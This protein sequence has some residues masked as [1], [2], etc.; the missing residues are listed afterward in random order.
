MNFVS[1]F[2]KHLPQDKS[3]T[4]LSIFFQF[5][6]ISR[7]NLGTAWHGHERMQGLYPWRKQHAMTCQEALR[8]MY[9]KLGQWYGQV[10]SCLF[11]L[12]RANSCF[13]CLVV[14]GSP[15]DCCSVVHRLHNTFQPL[16]E[17]APPASLLQAS[18]CRTRLSL[19]YM[20]VLSGLLVVYYSLEIKLTL[21]H[22]CP[23]ACHASLACSFGFVQARV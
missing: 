19:A 2:V 16:R 10:Y 5:Q 22:M 14:A 18:V 11:C 12:R 3:G 20:W 13:R 9:A 4:T 23:L 6:D 8:Y 17:S 21:H 7:L 15:E 1:A